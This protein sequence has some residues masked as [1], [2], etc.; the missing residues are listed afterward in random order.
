[1]PDPGQFGLP[2]AQPSLCWRGSC[3]LVREQGGLLP[4]VQGQGRIVRRLA[5]IL[6]VD[7][8]GYSRLMGLDEIGTTRTLRE[9]RVVS[10]AHVVTYGGRVVKNTG[11]GVLVEFP[12]VVDA[13]E[14]AIAVQVMM[15]ER[16]ADIPPDR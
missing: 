16:N 8:A 2:A 3:S 10:D 4:M 1:M 9:H 15:A 11:D 13:V 7:V 6:A 14:C 12:S 5:A